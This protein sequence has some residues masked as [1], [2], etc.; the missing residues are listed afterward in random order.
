MAEYGVTDSGFVLK[1]MD[2]II[3]EI[4]DDLTDGFG[5]NTKVT[6]PSYLDTLVTTFAG[7]IATLWE[8]AQES[9]YAK[10]PATATGKNLDNAVQYGGIRRGKTTATV[11][12][13]HCTGT[14]GTRVPYGSTVGTNTNPQVVLLAQN[15][16]SIARAAANALTIRPASTVVGDVYSVA[17]DGISYSFTCTEATDENIL[18]GLKAAITT[19][20]YT[21]TLGE[22]YLSIED[23]TTSR[24]ST[25]TL[26]D[27]LTTGTVTTIAAF[28]TVSLGRIEVPTGTITEI[29]DKV[30]GFTA[31]TN[32]NTPNYGTTQE[33]DVE[34]RHS[35]IA[36]LSHLSTAMLT[37]IKSA[38]LND[39]DGVESV[40]GY[41][42]DTD[43]TDADGLSPHSIEVVVEGGENTAIAEAILKTKACGIATNGT[44][45]IDVTTDNGDTVPIKFSRPSYIYLWIKVVLHGT[46]TNMPTNYE[47]L[48]SDSILDNCA[49]L[50][51]GD[52]LFIQ[53][54]LNDIYDK[55]AGVTY[56]D[57]YTAQTSEKGVEPAESDYKSGNVIITNK[58]MLM[59]DA[60]RIEVSINADG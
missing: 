59:V 37:S 10:F 19:D 29:I 15:S 25:F 53:T 30:A 35:Y 33:T 46:K 5:F 13:L 6:R 17:I 26:S 57:I 14:D 28:E 60:S 41:E 34:L 48:V 47:N 27:N 31:V 51:I 24:N 56:I 2:T 58:Q 32:K 23:K 20:S 50:E 8:V 49:E 11:Y 18:A 36:K 45:S 12:R 7:Q 21:I 38:L 40:Q 55:V 54:L 16:F 39:V 52:D 42:N 22:S 3:D 9:Y 43:T 44:I 1:R 4:H